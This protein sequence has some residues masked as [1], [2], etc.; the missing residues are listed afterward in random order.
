MENGTESTPV[1]SSDPDSPSEESWLNCYVINL[2]RSTDRWQAIESGFRG[3]PLRLIRVPAVDGKTLSL[4]N[5]SYSSFWTQ[6]K[7]GKEAMPSMIATYIS[8]I[9]AIRAFL[10]SGAEYGL[11]CEDD[12]QPVPEMMEIL[13]EAKKYADSWDMLRVA[14]QRETG[15]VTYRRL[16]PKYRLVTNITGMCWCA[17]YLLNRKAAKRLAADLLPMDDSPD[18]AIFRGRI[19]V[20]EAAIL[21][22]LLYQGDLGQQ[23]LHHGLIRTKNPLNPLWWTSR[24]NRLLTRSWRYWLQSA[25]VVRRVFYRGER[26]TKAEEKRKSAG[27]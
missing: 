26:S 1:V 4:P 16:T 25:R 6:I 15:T 8:H 5:L 18:P 9:N 21:P 17:G 22:S 13:G 14:V 12:V 23:T 19:G 3:Q 7:D 2:D 20:R 11:I 27:A 10:D 24:L